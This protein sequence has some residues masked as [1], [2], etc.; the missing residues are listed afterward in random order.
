MFAVL[1]IKMPIDGKTWALGEL[2]VPNMRMLEEPS[3]DHR[4]DPPVVVSQHIEPVRRFIVLTAQ[5]CWL[6]VF[7]V[8]TCGMICLLWCCLNG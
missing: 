6:P 5:V 8:Q 7:L 4:P 3:V 1:Q 2:G